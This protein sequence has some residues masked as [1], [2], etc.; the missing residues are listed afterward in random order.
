MVAR[1][2]AIVFYGVKRSKYVTEPNHK[3]LQV[4][5]KESYTEIKTKITQ[6]NMILMNVGS[7]LD[8]KSDFSSSAHI[9]WEGES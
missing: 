6:E 7:V 5:K 4:A 1:L 2:E 8:D 3:G 9:S